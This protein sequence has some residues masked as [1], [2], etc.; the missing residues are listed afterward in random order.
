M[1][2]EKISDNEA[3]DAAL[4]L[5]G[6]PDHVKEFYEDWAKTYNIDTTGSEYTG[7]AIAANLLH[8]H[9]MG[10]KRRALHEKYRKA[11]KCCFPHAE[12][13][14]L[15]LTFIRKTTNRGFEYFELNAR[16]NNCCINIRINIRISRMLYDQN[17]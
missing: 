3:I 1:S 5:D 6:D 17:W 7:P 13:L 10:E 14:I 11:R 4:H 8:Q 2:G 16:F 12:T 15:S 9:L